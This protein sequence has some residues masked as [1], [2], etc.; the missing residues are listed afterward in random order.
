MSG[1]SNAS[2][3]VVR[4]R[5]GGNCSARVAAGPSIMPM[6]DSVAGRSSRACRPA[7]VRSIARVLRLREWTVRQRACGGVFKHLLLDGTTIELKFRKGDYA[8]ARFEFDRADFRRLRAAVEEERS[9]FVR[10]T[11]MPKSFSE[12]GVRVT[13]VRLY[14]FFRTHERSD[15]TAVLTVEVG[16]SPRVL[17]LKRSKDAVSSNRLV[18]F[19]S[20]SDFRFFARFVREQFKQQ[21]ARQRGPPKGLIWLD[22]AKRVLRESYHLNPDTINRRIRFNKL[23][24]KKV[25]PHGRPAISLRR[26]ESLKAEFASMAPPEGS[27]KLAD[28]LRD[29]IYQAKFSKK[30]VRTA[31]RLFFKYADSAGQEQIARIYVDR[32][33]AYRIAKE[34]AEKIRETSGLFGPRGIYCSLDFVAEATG[35]SYLTVQTR[36]LHGKLLLKLRGETPAVFETVKLC[37][38][39]YVKRIDLVDYLRKRDGAHPL[40]VDVHAGRTVLCG[41]AVCGDFGIGI[42][43]VR[44]EEFT[45]KE[46]NLASFFRRVFFASEADAVRTILGFL[47]KIKGE[48]DDFTF[49][50]LWL[51]RKY[52]ACATLSSYNNSVLG[53][54]F[55]R[56]RVSPLF[57]LE[58]RN[59]SRI[60]FKPKPNGSFAGVAVVAHDI[61]GFG[62]DHLY[63]DSF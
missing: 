29:T 22:E 55:S 38:K 34:D 16:G 13:S 15:G 5:E 4:A 2:V 59:D 7:S 31:K 14:G 50:K 24:P 20:K 32:C 33:K 19:M 37:K 8:S 43:R 58:P 21:K 30:I 57:D 53:N 39:R 17:T 41:E 51:A 3:R 60:F 18:R 1:S 48:R 46:L 54:A 25:K 36:L 63:P 44:E 62:F 23:K 45:A 12:M 9:K 42:P 26:F 28:A 35:F 6:T 52:Y 61:G 56:P 47:G 27:V 40:E 10:L 11:E 49:A